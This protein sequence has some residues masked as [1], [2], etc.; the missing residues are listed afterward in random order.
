MINSTERWTFQLA[1]RDSSRRMGDAVNAAVDAEMRPNL[2]TNLP[3]PPRSQTTMQP[4]VLPV[5]AT[6]ELVKALWLKGKSPETVRAYATDIDLFCRFIG[7]SLQTATLA[8]LHAFAADLQA[9]EDATI[10]RRMSAVKS[11]FSFAHKTGYLAV[12]VGAAYPLPKLAD[13]L[14]ERILTEEQVQR[15]LALEANPRDHAL[16]RLLYTAG[17]RVSEAAGLTW[18]K[19]HPREDGRAQL[20]VFGKGRSTRYILITAATWTELAALQHLQQR[21][22]AGEVAAQA[23]A[24]EPV[25]A[26]RGANGKPGG[27]H[28]DPSQIHRIVAAAAKRAGINGNVSPHWLRHAHASHAL[29]RGAPIH[30]V[31]ATLGHGSL[32]VTGRYTHA[33]PSAS[34]SE[35]LPL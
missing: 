12:N 8:D 3:T 11:L 33:R 16:L 31:R 20:T 7:K 17:L 23:Q 35:Y 4:G 28:L 19:V 27:G 13:E 15:M 21:Q 32:A 24:A 6:D 26:S 29:D 18:G 34:S 30:L 9:L 22:H 2:P 1:A 14:A 5:G 10:K 25:F